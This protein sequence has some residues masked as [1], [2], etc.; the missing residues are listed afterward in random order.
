MLLFFFI[1]IILYEPHKNI[2][3]SD[4]PFFKKIFMMYFY[5]INIILG[6]VHEGGHG[7]CYILRCPQFITAINGTIF[8]L[9]FPLGIG[10]QF[11]KQGSK[12]GWFVGL[13]FTGMSS[14]YTSWYISTSRKMG[15]VVSANESF[16]GVE[17][18]HDFYYI[19]DTIGLVNFDTKISAVVKIL[20]VILMLYAIFRIY[21][22]AFMN[23]ED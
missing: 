7:I 18:F 14:M 8:Q 15:P 10:Y 1:G 16:L 21:V 3:A 12:I 6:M 9:A 17:G 13:F 4:G 23:K 11:R 22:D 5:V 19:L 20:A 2:V